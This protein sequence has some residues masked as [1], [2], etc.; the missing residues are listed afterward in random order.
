[1]IRSMTAFGRG[2]RQAGDKLITVEMRT[3]N[4]RFRDV[5]VRLPSQLQPLEG[6]LRA[7]TAR[8]LSRGR[9]DIF[10][11]MDTR[12]EQTNVSV[13]LNVPLA[14]AY[15]RLFQELREEFGAE[16]SFSA[17][18]LCQFKDVV[19]LKPLEEDA[20]FLKPPVLE[21]LTQALEAVG[22][23]RIHE[24]R[25]IE[26]D[27]RHRLGLIRGCLG[28][29]DARAPLVVE[30]YRGRLRDRIALVSEGMEIDGNRMAQEVAYF[31]NRCDIT[32][33]IV[34]TRA[35][36]ESFEEY[37]EAE[38]PVGRRLDFLVQEMNREVN[39]ISSKASDASI[40]RAAVEIKGELEKLREQIQNV[41]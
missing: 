27:F 40:S 41:E 23:M 33:E 35:H 1:M 22:R 16:A 38:E 7:M 18:T 15:V 26:M 37:L 3:V 9:I 12:G 6:D 29:I 25:A 24:G 11:N 8:A 13:A 28:E 19:I 30:D 20:E 14:R 17:E 34:R 21:A 36:I 4:H 31:A 5:S 10:V 2:E 32:E 39:T